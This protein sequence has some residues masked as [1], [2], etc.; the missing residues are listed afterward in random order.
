MT[1]PTP[2]VANV[3]ITSPITCNGG[4]AILTVTATGGTVPYTGAGTFTVAAGNYTYTVTDANGCSSNTTISVTEPTP[5]V[6]NVNIT[7]PITCNG[8]NAILTVTATGGTV[9]YTGIGTFTVAA[10]NYTYTVTDANGCSNNATITVT[11]PSPIQLIASAT[12]NTICI[13]QNTIL[14]GTGVNTYTWSPGL[15]LGASVTVTPNSSTTY[16]V[17]GTNGAGCIGTQTISINVNSLP[18]VNAGASQTICTGQSVTLTGTGSATSYTW[19]NGVIDNIAFTPTI[20]NSY[21]VMGTDVNSCSNTATVEVIINPI[22][23]LSLSASTNSICIGN[24]VLLSANGATTYTWNPGLL[25]GA[26]VTVNPTS[27]TTYSVNGDNGTGCVGTETISLLVQQLPNVLA[28]ASSTNICVGQTVSLTGSGATNYNW[29][30]GVIDGIAFSPTTTTSYIVLGT[31]IF[32]CTATTTILV[33]VYSGTAAIPSVNPGIICIGD[34]SYL[35]VI[36]GSIP[37]WSLNSNP[38]LLNVAPMTDVSY[39]YS[40][41]DNNGCIGDIIFNISIDEACAIKVY[42]GFTPNGDGINDFWIIDNIENYST[43][44][45][46]IYNRWGTLMYSTSN[47]NNFDNVWDGKFNGQ[48]VTSGTYFY[49]IESNQLI[50]KGWIEITN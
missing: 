33:N 43:N 31:D 12:N 5:I 13:G 20:S 25:S 18:V 15:L 6:A 30:N 41:V 26:S 9:P 2:I 32:G 40:A 8:G 29:N 50:K 42:N 14:N 3:N 27:N 22:L 11:Q 38:N 16:T 17:N 49:V 21:I 4:N 35:S 34:T 36:G 45:V 44:K 24:S 39:T 10:G 47:Y 7:S 1:E 46:Y 19:N 48:A 28:S 23:S 37:T